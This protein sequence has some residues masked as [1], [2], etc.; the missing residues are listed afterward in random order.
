MTA[1]TSVLLHFGRLSGGLFH[2][3]G[4]SLSTGVCGGKVGG[5]GAYLCVRARVISLGP[6]SRNS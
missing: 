2:R 6:L 3:A 1:K 5:C 4:V